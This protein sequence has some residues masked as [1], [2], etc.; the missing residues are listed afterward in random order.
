MPYSGSTA[1]EVQ[2]D[3]TEIAGPEHEPLR[4]QKNGKNDPSNR[5]L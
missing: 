4:K 1:Q 3:G 2:I 5:V